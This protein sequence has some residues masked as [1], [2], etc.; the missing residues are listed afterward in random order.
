[1]LLS[2]PGQQQVGPDL[3]A[4]LQG[5]HHGLRAVS[6]AELLVCRL[7][8]RLLQAVLRS[9]VQQLHGENKEPIILI[10]LRLLHRIAALHLA[11]GASTVIPP[12][13]AQWACT[14]GMLRI[15]AC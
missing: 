15:P 8:Q 2:G 3:E 13:V 11:G 9:Q 10:F 4:L 6:A 7:A 12:L 14:V 5:I 1:M